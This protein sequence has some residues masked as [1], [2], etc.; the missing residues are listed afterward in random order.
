MSF[1]TLVT[2]FLGMPVDSVTQPLHQWL[3][4]RPTKDHSG[5]DRIPGKRYYEASE[6]VYT[7][8]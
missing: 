1:K 4:S 2:E 7:M 3:V 8:F 6:D 5:G